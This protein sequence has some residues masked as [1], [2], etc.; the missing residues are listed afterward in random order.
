MHGY[1]YTRVRK[2]R[3]R[4]DVR[5]RRQIPTCIGGVLAR[6]GPVNIRLAK[7]DRPELVALKT[8]RRPYNIKVDLKPESFPKDREPTSGQGQ[9]K[10]PSHPNIDITR[11]SCPET[12]TGGLPSW[13]FVKRKKETYLEVTLVF[14]F[15]YGHQKISENS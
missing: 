9:N 3:G 14:S 7:N 13:P 4:S 1:G 11:C 6:V 8:G 15:G 2:D 10:P 5:Y 12:S